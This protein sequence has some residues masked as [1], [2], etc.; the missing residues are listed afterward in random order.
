[1]V[2]L[3]RNITLLVILLFLLTPIS[4]AA[5][6]NFQYDNNGNI[7]KDM[8]N[9]Y[10]YDSFN[11]L[12]K[13][14]DLNKK[15]IE[16]YVYDHEGNRI[17]KIEYL[18]SGKK[19]TYYPDK[20]LVREVVG[21]NKKDTVYYYDD[22]GILLA[23]KDPD[24]KKY[25]Y[26]PDHLGST[27]LITDSSGNKVEETS[28]L[29]Y[30][31]VLAGGKKSKFLYTGKEKDSTGLTYFGARYYNPVLRQ[32]TQPDSLIQDIYDPQAL[33]RYAYARNNPYTYKDADGNLFF[34]AAAAWAI[35]GAVV[36]A[37]ANMVSQIYNSGA[38]MFDG[39]M[40]WGSVGVSSAAGGVGGLVGGIGYQV[41]STA[42]SATLGSGIIS[43]TSTLIPTLTMASVGEQATSNLFSGNSIT[44][45][46]F[47][48]AISGAETGAIVGLG[49]GA[50]GRISNVASKT[51]Q[52]YSLT[53]GNVQM[54]PLKHLYGKHTLD[55]NLIMTPEKISA[56]KIKPPARIY[57]YEGR[58]IIDDG[59][60]R[61]GRYALRT[62]KNVA[63][64]QIMNP[65]PNDIRGWEWGRYL[66]HSNNNK[67]YRMD[68]LVEKMRKQ[69]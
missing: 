26:H 62:S 1:M 68:L 56:G 41:F 32:F 24:G 20:S 6:F 46:V 67:N 59:Q 29:P 50:L 18:N 39:S 42:A 43:S 45:N 66:W 13:V 12:I 40:N 37:G 17:K 9:L 52:S 47:D 19:I 57:N 49:A 48:S 64:G 58:L 36:S 4:F 16:E 61:T 22:G 38:S 28:Y 25:Y 11:H 51:S 3:G 63:P 69:K 55:K 44:N 53:N 31:D 60:G 34:L 35:G 8:Y 5:N 2:K 23:R 10:K 33:N 7:L 30:G 54:F 65:S 14:Y 15:L 21:S 27:T